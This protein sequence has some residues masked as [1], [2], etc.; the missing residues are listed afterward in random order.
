MHPVSSAYAAAVKQLSRLW[1]LRLQITTTVGEV[2]ELDKSNISLGS[3]SFKEGATC[4]DTVQVGSTFSNSIEFELINK[5]KQFNVYDFT[6]AKVV[7]QIGLWLEESQVFEYVPLG[8]FFVLENG[9][10]FSTIPFSC[11]DRMSLATRVFDDSQIVYPAALTEVFAKAATQ[12]GATVSATLLAEVEDLG[13]A[14][15]SLPADTVSC[16]DIFTG[17]GVLIAK[18]LRMNRAGYLESFWYTTPVEPEG[19]T[20]PQTRTGNSEFEDTKVAV[21]G[22][23]LSDAYGNAF[24]VGTDI[25]AIE[26]PSSPIIQGEEMSMRALN[27]ALT[28]LRQFEYQPA[29]V[30]TI[31]DPAI[32]AG[33]VIIHRDTAV[34]T[35]TLPVMTSVYKFPGYGILTTLGTPRTSLDQQSSTDKKFKQAFARSSKDRAILESKI[36]QTA[37][38]ILFEVSETYADWESFA[39][40]SVEVDGIAGTVQDHS[41]NISQLIQQAGKVKLSVQ[42]SK[43]ELVTTIDST[44]WEAKHISSTGV[45]LSGFYFDFALGR[46]VYDGTGIYRSEDGSAYIQIENDGISVY[47]DDGTGDVAK[48]M[49]IG[50]NLSGGVA[51]PYVLMG[52]P[53]NKGEAGLIKK[54]SNGLF[55]GN[56][57]AADASGA[58]NPTTNY[59]GIFVNTKVGKTYVVNGTDMQNVYT[60]EAIAKF[61]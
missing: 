27:T 52:A 43:G 46:F 17:I 15:N 13:L 37:E 20:S 59:T 18:N 45:T 22:C 25:Y 4:A 36:A 58:F 24:S 51:Y 33:D 50:F 32:Q 56:G 21:T 8:E 9:K 6:G 19:A 14:V 31:G 54:F 40:L 11:F 49:H 57:Y 48:K 5:N 55:I 7:P 28:R 53:E 38:Q 34:G 47:A 3:F 42:T 39:Q 41:N 30:Y 26:L 23:Y 2:L 61:A 10:R 35:V 44:T 1:D 60:G 29:E 12:C 16:R